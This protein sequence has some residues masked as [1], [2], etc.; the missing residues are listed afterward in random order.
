MSADKTDRANGRTVTRADLSESFIAGL[1]FREQNRLNS[2]E[3]SSMR[4]ATSWRAAK[5]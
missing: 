5:Q 3:P 2:S 4:F 1:A